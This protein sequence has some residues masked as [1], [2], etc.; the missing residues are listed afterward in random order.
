M[1]D[2]ESE[3]RLAVCTSCESAYAAKVW[4]DGAIKPIGTKEGCRCGSTE[5]QVVDQSSDVVP[6]TSEPTDAV[7]P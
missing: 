4:P 7:D 2:G 3:R 1:P 6:K 5:F